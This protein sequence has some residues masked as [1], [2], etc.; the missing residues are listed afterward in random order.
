MIFRLLQRLSMSPTLDADNPVFQATIQQARWWKRSG[1]GLRWAYAVI[2]AVVG[3][4][5]PITLWGVFRS[6]QNAY[7]YAVIV[8]LELAGLAVGAMLVSVALGYAIAGVYVFYGW[9]TAALF[10]QASHPTT[11][12]LS[13]STIVY[14]LHQTA[15]RRF[16]RVTCGIIAVRIILMVGFIAPILAAFFGSDPLTRTG[17]IFLSL[18][19]LF[20]L[21]FGVGYCLH[22]LWQMQALSAWGIAANSRAKPPN[23]GFLWGL[24]G[25]LT[26]IFGEGIV[27]AM[28]A[29]FFATLPRDFRATA[30]ILLIFPALYFVLICLYGLYSFVLKTCLEWSV[31][32]WKEPT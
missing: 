22:P 9:R 10:R 8:A 19:C 12:E 3:L 4:I 2:G 17:T 32:H 24:L 21:G 14:G 13:P 26:A 20:A 16:W 29:A 18:F 27:F 11:M 7:E 1:D 25:I 15:V 30:L 5:L 23:A 6:L 31:S 28:I